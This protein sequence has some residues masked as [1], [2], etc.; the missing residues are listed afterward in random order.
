MNSSHTSFIRLVCLLVLT[1]IAFRAGALTPPQ[2]AFSINLPQV[3]QPFSPV[4]LAIDSSGNVYAG[5]SGDVVA[6]MSGN[7][8]FITQWSSISPSSLTF[9]NAIDYVFVIDTEDYTVNEFFPNGT[10]Y[11][12]WGGVGSGAGQF[13]GP[14]GIAVAPDGTIFVADA[15]NQRIQMFNG[16]VPAAPYITSWG[17]LGDGPGQIDGPGGIAVDSSNNVY[18]IDIPTTAVN[19]FRIQRFAPDGTYF[20]QWFTPAETTA[21]VGIAGITTDASG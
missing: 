11:Q 2:Y 19:N 21:Y 16:S 14:S 13:N 20:N 12:V 18:V 6:K 17:T 5:C 4:S 3:P 15:F 9:D 8:S 10:N 7:G 1:L